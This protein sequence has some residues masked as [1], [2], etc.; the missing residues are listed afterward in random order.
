M[1]NVVIVS[2]T[3]LIALGLLTTVAMAGAPAQ[4][5]LQTDCYDSHTTRQE[6]H[7]CLSE[8]LD[9][10][11]AELA[12]LQEE[13]I[14]DAKVFDVRMKHTYLKSKVRRSHSAWVDYRDIECRRRRELMTDGSEAQNIYLH[15][16]VEKANTRIGELQSMEVSL[17]KKR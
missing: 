1:R 7:Q 5:A 9:A 10:A 4:T 11:E 14:H 17:P 8:Q 3:G 15:C 13:A 16:M 6:I 2:A 12:R